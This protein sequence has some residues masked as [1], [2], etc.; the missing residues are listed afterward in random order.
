MSE[1]RI[2][3]SGPFIVLA[4]RTSEDVAKQ[5]AC[6]NQSIG[7]F[8]CLTDLEFLGG[9]EATGKR[10]T[11]PFDMQSMY[12]FPVDATS[13][14]IIPADD[15]GP[16]IDLSSMQKQQQQQ[17]HPASST[18]LSKSEKRL[19]KDDDEIC[20]EKRE[21]KHKKSKHVSSKKD[22]KEKTRS[23]AKKSDEPRTVTKDRRP[24]RSVAK[25]NYREPILEKE[26][27][28][29]DEGEDSDSEW[30]HDHTALE[31]DEGDDDDDED[32]DDDDNR[33]LM[34]LVP[35][36]SKTKSA[37][38]K[39]S[40][41]ISR[42]TRVNEEVLTITSAKKATERGRRQRQRGGGGRAGR[43]QHAGTRG[44]PPIHTDGLS[45]YQRLTRENN[46]LRTEVCNLNILLESGPNAQ[47]SIALQMQA[48]N[49]EAETWRTRYREL[50]TRSSYE[51]ANLQH[52][53]RSMS[54]L[55]RK[56]QSSQEHSNICP[57]NVVAVLPSAEHTAYELSNL[58]KSWK[59]QQEACISQLTQLM[60]ATPKPQ[61]VVSET[62]Q[63]AAELEL[64]K[65][66]IR[67]V[68]SKYKCYT[69]AESKQLPLQAIATKLEK[70][71]FMLDKVERE[72]DCGDNSS[73]AQRYQVFFFGLCECVFLGKGSSICSDERLM[74]FVLNLL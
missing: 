31:S 42:L 64:V 34:S 10:H 19:A 63:C 41:C 32:D 6:D 46:T 24:K 39:P 69:N 61:E 11:N 33:S 29:E 20:A 72:M 27:E 66:Q 8:S 30:V 56:A 38:S 1:S 45:A 49:N 13:Q 40:N 37:A 52:H 50:E 18:P 48:Q 21:H 36:P 26:L 60:P 59:E 58:I 65:T 7:N 9:G 4:G 70:L 5:T 14:V 54:S 67:D 35:S 74:T 12:E 71:L 28:N 17:L 47:R 22:K 51:I 73:V 15:F 68:A 53:L 3:D 57:E 44:R 62:T 2:C 16:Q 43:G 25:V 55:L 23:V